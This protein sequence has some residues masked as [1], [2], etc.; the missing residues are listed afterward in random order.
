MPRAGL[1]RERVVAEAALVADEAGLDRLTLAAVAKRCG[2]SLPGLYKHVDGLDSVRRDI[3]V[4]AVRELTAALA[5]AAAGRA[6]RDALHAIARAYR[7]YAVRHP[8]RAAASVRAPAPGDEEHN[9]AG[10]AAVS[11]IAAVLAGYGIEGADAID[12][13]R[14]LRAALHGFV[15]LE[16]AGGFGLAQSVDA[17]FT[18]YI[19]ALDTA[20]RTWSG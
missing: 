4:L 13:I 15:T 6:E 20:F 5:A 17:T 10:N 12:A 18:R 7:E 8:G 16:T 14:S 2:V 9:A 1:T 11:L 3:T 19:D